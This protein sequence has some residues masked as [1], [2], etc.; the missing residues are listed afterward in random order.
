MAANA[1]TDNHPAVLRAGALSS[2]EALSSS[3]SPLEPEE[4][5]PEDELEDEPEDP[6]PDPELEVGMDPIEL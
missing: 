6:D 2:D 4:P 5:D 3:S 1:I